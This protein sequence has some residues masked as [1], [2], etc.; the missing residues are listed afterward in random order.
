M[1]D[2]QTR[3]PDEEVRAETDAKE[4]R[5]M[6]FYRTIGNALRASR[7][8]WPG[9]RAMTSFREPGPPSL[10]RGTFVKYIYAPQQGAANARLCMVTINGANE[11]ARVAT[12]A[13]L[14]VAAEPTPGSGES[15]NAIGLSVWCLRMDNGGWLVLGP[16]Q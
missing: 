11:I 12:D 15:N 10:V 3:V 16:I 14:K 8:G 9:G 13:Q 5:V 2:V 6:A 7:S 1:H 4:G